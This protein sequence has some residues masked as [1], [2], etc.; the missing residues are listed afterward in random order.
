MMGLEEA[1]KGSRDGREMNNASSA[2]GAIDIRTPA[3]TPGSGA[4]CV[5]G[6]KGDIEFK[7][8]RH[9]GERH[10][11]WERRGVERE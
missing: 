6:L 2:T 1:C 9:F 5:V 10:T 8:S 4:W 11:C 7:L 3:R